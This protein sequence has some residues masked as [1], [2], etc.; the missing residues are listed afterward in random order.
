MRQSDLIKDLNNLILLPVTDWEE[1]DK[2][3]R[4]SDQASVF[5]HSSYLKT[6]E[7]AKA[8]RYM[9]IEN[10]TIGGVLIP[11]LFPELLESS[12]RDFATYQSIW[13][14]QSQE[15]GFRKNLS[16]INILSNLASYLLKIDVEIHLS[17][18]WS[19]Q[20][21]RG[22]DWAFFE[23]PD[24]TIQFI[25]R[26]TGILNLTSFSDFSEYLSSI[27]SGRR[28]DFKVGEK[29]KISKH[30]EP[31][32]VDLFLEMYAETVP[33]LDFKTKESALMHVRKVVLASIEA[34]T[35]FLWLGQDVYGKTYS[36]VFMQKFAGTLYYQFGASFENDLKYSPN[37][38]LLLKVIQNAFTDGINS[39]D[40]VGINSPARGGFKSGLN[41]SPQ[42]YF[43]VHIK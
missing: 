9:I 38:V 2:G 14:K 6:C 42:L 26:Y 30:E 41:P 34:G 3:L 37:A 11:E 43:Q 27:A 7:L 23:I 12:I 33:F 20:D 13:I 4:E 15:I 19:I 22:L 1:W 35:G 32:S 31:Q 39:I 36:G 21:I 8:A 24:K 18:H 10:Q 16:R 17:L 40:F 28:A 29:L 25:P 5:L